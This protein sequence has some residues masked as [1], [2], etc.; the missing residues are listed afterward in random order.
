MQYILHVQIACQP[1]YAFVES[2]SF[3]KWPH[4]EFITREYSIIDGCYSFSFFRLVW[5]TL[6]VIVATIVAML[7]PFF[8]HFVGLLG[9]I[10]FWPITVY[11]PIEMY[12]AQKKVTRFSR[13]WYGLQIL[14]LFCLIVSLLA[15][16][17]S[18]HGLVKS[19]IPNALNHVI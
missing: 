6:Y 15:A 4:N 16:V 2:W 12:I 8:N 13:A 17:G 14:S 9:A 1:I 11:F 10:T 5:R 3:K 19:V 18:V 7:F